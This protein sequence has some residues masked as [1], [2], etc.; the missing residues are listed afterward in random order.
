MIRA[1]AYHGA[2]DFKFD[3]ADLGPI[4]VGNELTD[5]P[6]LLLTDISHTRYLSV[7]NGNIQGSE[8][9]AIFGI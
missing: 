2:H 5:E 7:D 9:V 3:I 6:V 4:K 8:I 1:V